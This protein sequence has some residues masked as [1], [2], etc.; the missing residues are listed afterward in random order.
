MYCIFNMKYFEQRDLVAN[1]IVMFSTDSVP[2]SAATTPTVEAPSSPANAYDVI[3]VETHERPG[4]KRKKCTSDVWQYFTKYDVVVEENGKQV[5]QKWARCNFKGCN[6]KTSKHR[7][8]GRAGTTGFW[9]HLG[10]YHSIVKGQQQLKTGTDTEK[11]VSVVE[12]FRYDPEQSLK[13][14]YIAI[15]MHEYPFNIVEHE[16][17]I[18]WVKSLRPDFPLKSRVSVRKDIMDIYLKEKDKLYEYLKTIKCRFSATMDMW[19]SNQNKGYMCVTLHWIDTD[20]KIQKRIINFFHVKG[21]H[22]GE[23]LSDSLSSCLLKWYVE[24]KMFSLT[25]DNAAAN[26][27]AVKD[28]ILELKKHSPLICDGL[29]FHVRCANH[30]LNLVA[31]DGMRVIAKATDNIRA[32]VVAVKGSPLQWEEFLKCATECGL[33]TNTGLSLDVCTRWNSTYMMLRDAL[34]YKPAFERLRSYGRCRYEKVSPSPAEWNMAH[35]L[36]PFLKKFFDL[37][38]LFS[39]TLYPTENLFFRGFCEIKLLLIG[40][41]NHTDPTISNM[42]KSMTAK[43]DKYWK[44]SNTAL[45][46]ANVLDPRYKRK[47]VEYY[48]MKLDKDSYQLELEKF[49]NVLRKMYQCYV[50]STPSAKSKEASSVIDTFMDNEDNELDNFLY[51][52]SH[53]PELDDELNDLDKYLK[54]PPLKIVKAD[55]HTFDILSWWKDKQYSYPILSNLAR[56]VLA[57]QASTVASESAFSSGGRVIDPFRSRLDPEMVEALICSRDWIAA[58]RKG[59]NRYTCPYSTNAKG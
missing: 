53:D 25:L 37:T 39:G 31:R 56:D 29:F 42:A 55:Q 15:I 44:K 22:T 20:W 52:E 13:K 38:E 34:Y 32:F 49:N 21:R 59:E 6:N 17:F 4:K 30:I 26:D 45:A 41:H 18:D 9:T 24:K 58:A 14:L 5:K 1:E 11:G 54:D 16:Y 10:N 27:V 3:N 28:V 48:L 23:K 57:M 12:R 50:V 19:T 47:V 33:D 7:A 51:E 46:V 43:F 8:E 40:W 35:T 36:I 2:S